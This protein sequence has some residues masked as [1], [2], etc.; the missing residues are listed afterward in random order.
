M[1]TDEFFQAAAEHGLRIAFDAYFSSNPFAEMLIGR[2]DRLSDELRIS[3][4]M[5][6]EHLVEKNQIAFSMCSQLGLVGK[7]NEAY[8][9][10][11]IK[12]LLND[13][14]DINKEQE[15][16]L[17][18]EK[19]VLF[20]DFQKRKKNLVQ[21]EVKTPSVDFEP[22]PKTDCLGLIE[23]KLLI[24]S[25][26][27]IS[28]LRHLHS[29]VSNT[30]FDMELSGLLQRQIKLS[31]YQLLNLISKEIEVIELRQINY[32]LLNLVE[33]FEEQQNQKRSSIWKKLFK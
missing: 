25:N 17:M 32:A 8:H 5:S 19:G 3:H 21:T 16:K 24:K 22:I 29:H 2:L 28:A 23:I 18:A 9:L 26:D 33:R 31:K 27:N 4:V 6:E 10:K 12:Q 30:P 1:T 11:R 20:S 13:Y 14:L 7:E 15:E